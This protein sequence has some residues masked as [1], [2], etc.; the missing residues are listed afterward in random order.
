MLLGGRHY[1]IRG[2]EYEG[3]FGLEEQ[4]KYWVKRAVELETGAKKI[5]KFVFYETFVSTLGAVSFNY[6]RS[7]E[8]EARV[9]EV[10]RGHPQF[11]QGFAVIDPA[12][13][14]IRVIDRINGRPLDLLIEDLHLGHEHYFHER[15]P[16]IMARLIGV[17]EA[18]AFLHRA[19]EKHGDI[20]RD[21]ILV[22]SS[23][24]TYKWIDFDLDYYQPEHP[25]GV[26]I[27]GLGNVLLYVAG[28]GIHTVSD[29]FYGRPEV[30]ETLRE[31]DI[32]LVLKN[33]VCNLGKLFP[34]IPKKLNNILLHFSSGA[35]VFYESADELIYD[36]RDYLAG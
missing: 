22:E 4:P 2:H 32:S 26:D 27:F 21:H 17:F 10:V 36:L 35:D 29:V 31:E 24:G 9:L 33:R 18:I 28:M 15:A 3:R 1:L 11:M 23:T 14:N 13:N 5:L 6:V 19:G 20:R 8:K 7:P 12:G 30:F 34:Y 25:F 16:A